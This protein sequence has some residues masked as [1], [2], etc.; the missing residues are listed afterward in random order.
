MGTGA[1]PKAPTPRLVAVC[2]LVASGKSSVAERLA[3]LLGAEHVG[4][5]ETRRALFEAGESEAF[6]PGFSKQVYRELFERAAA[7]LD[8]GRSVVLDGTFRTR[9]L[10]AEARQVAAERGLPFLCVECRA[11]VEVCR[12]RVRARERAGERGWE[13]LFEKFLTL[14][15]PLE[16]LPP[17]EHAVLDTSGP[18]AALEPLV[19]DLARSVL[20]RM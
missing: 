18:P 5:D 17:G 15:E 8:A 1:P 14:W 3:A 19:V 2:G 13:A 9:R 10:R 7:A 20:K 16:E 12:E 6:V 11:A 4:A